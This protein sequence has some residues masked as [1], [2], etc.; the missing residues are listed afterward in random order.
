[1]LTAHDSSVGVFLRNLHNL[2]NLLAKGEAHA[3]AAGT[4]PALLLRARLA[5][6]MM[7]LAAQVVWTTEAAKLAVG[8]L[9]GEVSPPSKAPIE[10]F[11]ELHRRIDDAIAWLGAVPAAEVEAGVERTIEIAWRGTS[12]TFGGSDF[13]LQF[14]LPNFWFHFTSAYAILRNQ[15]VPVTKADYTGLSFG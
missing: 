12:T 7:D 5:D 1:M 4:D 6:D 9:L 14:A 3:V 2:K 11:A 8:R 13:L 10:S 15:G